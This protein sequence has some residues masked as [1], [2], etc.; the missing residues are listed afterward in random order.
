MAKNGIDISGATLQNY[1]ATTSGTHR[2]RQT[3]N[4]CTKSSASVS[5]N[6]IACSFHPGGK[7]NN[8]T[9][10]G[11]F[12]LAPN[13]FENTS[14]LFIPF[15]YFNAPV[16]VFVYDALGKVSR[17]SVTRSSGKFVVNRN[18]ATSG[19]YFLQVKDGSNNSL[20]VT[21]IVLE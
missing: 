14:D 15:E 11:E 5:L 16:N 4:G 3:A 9:L 19:I 20:Y 18:D 7:E 21:K 8:N 17:M 10:S 13:P 2:V 6:V 12:K 1:N